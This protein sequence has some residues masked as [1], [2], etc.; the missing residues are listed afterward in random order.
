[1]KIPTLTLALALGLITPLGAQEDPGTQSAQRA[2]NSG[3][4]L[5]QAAEL[6]TY[7]FTPQHVASH[8][9]KKLAARLY[10]R[11]LHIAD[12]GGLAAPPVENL[13]QLGDTILIYDT[14]EY[15]QMLGEALHGMDM[16]LAEETGEAAMS[17]HHETIVATWSPNHIG[18]RVAAAALTSFRRDAQVFDERGNSNFLPNMSTVDEVNQLIL[19]DTPDQVKQMLAMLERIDL[20]EEQLYLTC[21]VIRGQH[22]PSTN[23]TSVPSVLTTNL[24]KLV[25]Y[26]HFELVTMGVLRASVLTEDLQISMDDAYRLDLRDLGYDSESNGLTAMCGFRS[27]DGQSLETR[28]TIRAGEYTV[29]GATGSSPLFAVLKIEPIDL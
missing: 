19:R 8:E 16:A 27:M 18:L 4:Q 14:E 24:S 20:P 17:S 9:L 22:A 1:M 2:Q 5:V 12:R 21:L 6:K 23:P 29:L 11:Q 15:A 26:E 28:T 10:G 25:P 7:Y 13:Q 3:R